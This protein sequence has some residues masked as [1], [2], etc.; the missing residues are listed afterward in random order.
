MNLEI[1]IE[2]NSNIKQGGGQGRNWY[3]IQTNPG[4]ENAVLKN[5]RT[6]IEAL[7]QEDFI[8]NVVVP[9]EKVLKM[10]R[11]K[12]VE[13]EVKIYPGYILVD[14][15]VNDKSWWVVR[16]TPRVSGFL[17]TGSNPVPVSNTEMAGILDRVNR[18][19][20]SVSSDYEAGN[21]IRIIGGTF[22]DSL[23]E[24]IEVDDKT[25]E[26][27]VKIEFFGRDTE[28]NLPIAQLKK[29]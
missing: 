12:Q 23:G 17:G 24:I 8:F 22:K 19:A 13:E 26:A 18:E 10:K 29:I 16:N 7:E 11:G 2:D 5:L 25:S 4:Y 27:R 1:D 15:I 9:T 3:A 6:R 28:V 14:M 20:E 21:S